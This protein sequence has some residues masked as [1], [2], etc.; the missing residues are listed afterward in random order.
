MTFARFLMDYRRDN[1]LGD[2]GQDFRRDLSA[3]HTGTDAEALSYLRH[4]VS[5]DIKRIVEQAWR[6]YRRKAAV[7]R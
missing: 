2:L 7:S 1:V 3:P 6:S 5:N 4:R